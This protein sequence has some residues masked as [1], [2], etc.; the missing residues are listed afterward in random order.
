MA[1]G[2]RVGGFVEMPAGGFI[3]A[4]TFFGRCSAVCRGRYQVKLK[5]GVALPKL[6]HRNSLLPLISE[7]EAQRLMQT[8]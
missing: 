2:F 8:P 7:L 3:A 5:Q 4:S 1:L 6:W